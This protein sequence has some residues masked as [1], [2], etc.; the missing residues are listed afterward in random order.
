[1]PNP[2]LIR[3]CI[4]ALTYEQRTEIKDGLLDLLMGDSLK[5]YNVAEKG[6][7]YGDSPDEWHP[8]DDSKSILDYLSEVGF[9]ESSLSRFITTSSNPEDLHILVNQVDLYIFDPLFLTLGGEFSQLINKLEGAICN[10]DKPFCILIPD[11]L[12]PEINQRFSQICEQ[13]LPL[14]KYAYERGCSGEWKAENA[15]RLT[16]FLNR[17]LRKIKNLPPADALEKFVQ[18]LSAYGIPYV[19]LEESPKMLG[20]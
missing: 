20:R 9:E 13:N 3:I 19:T 4:I 8:F 1:M 2:T 16:A 6:R 15:S 14:L 17:L 18:A 5:A 11:R 12:P 10:G 7:I